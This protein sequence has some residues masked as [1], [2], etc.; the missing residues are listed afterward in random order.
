MR[1]TMHKTVPYVVTYSQFANIYFVKLQA[2]TQ[3]NKI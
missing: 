3:P 2:D 1:K